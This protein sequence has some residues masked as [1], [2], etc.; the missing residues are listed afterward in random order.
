[1][2]LLHTRNNTLRDMNLSKNQS[3]RTCAQKE[4]ND[5]VVIYTRQKHECIKQS[6]ATYA[7]NKIVYIL[8]ENT[9]ENKFVGILALFLIKNLFYYLDTALNLIYLWMPTRK[10]SE[11]IE[12]NTENTETTIEGAL[13]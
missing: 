11:I 7:D 13:P 12:D 6:I 3:K 8:Y 10:Q 1:M 2:R 5:L 4:S 9:Y